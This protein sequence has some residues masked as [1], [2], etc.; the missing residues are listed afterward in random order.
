V[1]NPVTRLMLNRRLLNMFRSSIGS[2]ARFLW[3]MKITSVPKL[4]SAL[5][6]S[7]LGRASVK[8]TLPYAMRLSETLTCSTLMPL[9]Q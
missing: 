4:S 2:L 5:P 6:F 8:M 7:H 3:R 9:N 1:K